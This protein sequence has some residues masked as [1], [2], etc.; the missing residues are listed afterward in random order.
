MKA[1]FLEE[2]CGFPQ[3][4]RVANPV[5]SVL[6]YHLLPRHRRVERIRVN[7]RKDA[8]GVER[9]VEIRDIHSLWQL[10]RS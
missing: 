7:M 6:P 9:S 8:F 2:S 10:L 1:N 4:E 3:D 5:K